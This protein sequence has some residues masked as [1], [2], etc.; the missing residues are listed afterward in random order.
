MARSGVE[1]KGEVNFSGNILAFSGTKLDCRLHGAFPSHIY[2][3]VGHRAASS[4]CQQ[5]LQ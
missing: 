2:I 1:R 5:S 3:T 4:L